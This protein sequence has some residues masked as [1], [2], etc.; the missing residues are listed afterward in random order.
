MNSFREANGTV[1]IDSTD[2]VLDIPLEFFQTLEPGYAPV[3][4]GNVRQFSEESHFV[5]IGGDQQI[6]AM[7][8]STL[9]GFI[10]KT[11]V[12]RE[13]W[14]AA[15]VEPDPPAAPPL[16]PA[17]QRRAAYV[18]DADALFLKAQHYQAEAEGHRLNE[19]L[20]LA[21][22][23][24]EKARDFLRAYAAKKSEIRALYPDAEPE[25]YCLNP[26]GTYHRAEC[27]SASESGMLLTL[28][29]LTG[30]RPD[31]KPCSRCNPPALIGEEEAIA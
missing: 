6:D 26:S 1:R 15:Q 7:N 29:A 14:N 25:K 12:Y 24:E 30:S 10:D 23:A 21:L 3:G 16:S 17:D 5:I 8:K 11:D 20:D 28:T 4:F 19:H 22:A 27:A 2:G 18:L 9:L 13:T 31:A